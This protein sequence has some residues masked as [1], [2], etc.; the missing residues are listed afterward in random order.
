MLQDSKGPIV[1]LFVRE[2]NVH[3]DVQLGKEVSGVK[4]VKLLDLETIVP[5]TVVELDIMESSVKSWMIAMMKAV[6][7]VLLLPLRA[8]KENALHNVLRMKKPTR[9]VSVSAR[10]ITRGLEE[11]A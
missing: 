10:N 3:R 5:V 9:M 7:H 4:M 1:R 2:N 6:N 8:M 11:L